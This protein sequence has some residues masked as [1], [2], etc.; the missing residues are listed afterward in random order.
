MATLTK[1]ELLEAI[2]DM[3]ED[4]EIGLC[5]TCGFY[6]LLDNIKVQKLWFDGKQK[7]VITLHPYPVVYSC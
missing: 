3:P 4:M 6:Q 5:S 7:E 1:K 2:K